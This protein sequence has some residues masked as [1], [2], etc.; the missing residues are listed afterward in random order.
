[1]LYQAELHPEFSADSVLARHSELGQFAQTFFE[2]AFGKG[3]QRSKRLI[4]L[5]LSE[6]R[7]VRKPPEACNGARDFRQ[8][9]QTA[10][11]DGLANHLALAAIAVLHCVDQGESG[12]P[13]RQVIAEVFP[14]AGLVGLVVERIVNQLKGGADVPAVSGKGILDERRGVAEHRADLCAG[15]EQ[16][17]GFAVESRRC[18]APRWCSRHA[19]S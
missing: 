17:R 3:G 18:S 9:D 15:L 11:F 7:S 2:N 4:Y 16:P 19:H 8:L 13:L 1:M 14:E 5:A 6:A 12:F 10:F